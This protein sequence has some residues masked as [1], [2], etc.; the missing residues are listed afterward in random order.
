M[1]SSAGQSKV[2][3]RVKELG[4]CIELVSIDPYFHQVSVGL[5]IKSGVLTI[6]S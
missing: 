3:S 6:F 4:N 2:A 1:R 5:F